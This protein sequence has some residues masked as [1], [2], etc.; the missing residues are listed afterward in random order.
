MTSHPGRAAGCIGRRVITVIRRTPATDYW[1]QITLPARPVPM[2]T[3][4]I[5]PHDVKSNEK[6]NQQCR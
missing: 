3:C 1:R 5:L 6:N 4:I 2:I